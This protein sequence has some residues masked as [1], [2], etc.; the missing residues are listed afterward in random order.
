[1]NEIH[2]FTGEISSVASAFGALVVL[3]RDVQGKDY[4]VISP[5]SKRLFPA[6]GAQKSFAAGDRI[7]GKGVIGIDAV[8]VTEFTVFRG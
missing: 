5:A 3:D 8:L 4:A 2:E 6:A 1:M 7:M